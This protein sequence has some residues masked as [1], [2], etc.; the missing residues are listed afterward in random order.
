VKKAFYN[1]NSAVGGCL[2]GTRE[3]LLCDITEWFANDDPN[4]S[5]VFWL[6]GMAGAG[7]S[8]IAMSVCSILQPH[9]GG[10]L[11]FSRDDS[12][13]R[14]PSKIIPT[15]VYQLA[16]VHP[17]LQQ[18]IC[19]TIEKDSDIA[20]L[21][22]E[23]QAR[24]LVSEAIVDF[25]KQQKIQLPPLLFV[26]DALD[27]C[28]KVNDQ[29]GGTSIPLLIH[30]LHSLPFRIK[31]LIT[32][33][34]ESSIQ[35]MMRGLKNHTHP[36]ILHDIDSQ[37]VKADIERYFE[38]HLKVIADDKV[39]ERPWPTDAQKQELIRRSGRLFIYASTA[40]KFVSQSLLPKD[41]LALF[42][43]PD[44]QTSQSTHADLDAVYTK[45]VQRVTSGDSGDDRETAIC[46]LFRRV[47]GSIIILQQP[48]SAKDL[49]ALLNEDI[50]RI[51]S[52]TRSLSSLLDTGSSIDHPIRTFHLSFSDFLT[53]RERCA[54]PRLYIDTDDS[55]LLLATRCF[56]VMNEQLK[57]NICGIMDPGLLNS[58]V[59]NLDSLL[60]E[61]VS[62]ELRYACT[63]WPVHLASVKTITNEL[64]EEM[65]SFCR[66]HLLHWIEVLSLLK[67]LR[68][69][70][71]G[72]PKVIEWCKVCE[73]GLSRNQ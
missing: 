69:A 42:L 7:K 26:L 67:R 10:S 15:L 50:D 64:V 46:G 34:P 3:L 61:K 68:S 27:E 22:V 4:S 43:L 45:I 33:R 57:R 14:N 51:Y 66:K 53:S 62:E 35:K 44:S 63:Y 2:P 72:L 28:D 60:K 70:V 56:R 49:H 23:L 30:Y 38:H 40:V 5:S 58:E 55:N 65:D 20:A 19:D 37:V 54:D 39:T 73:D 9:I 31:V 25:T 21:A 18:S 8:A 6:S 47:V 29:E 24:K 12:D 16:K 11:F 17:A 59:P 36:Y 1:S 32:S 13:R 71:E 41:S 48:L 52:L